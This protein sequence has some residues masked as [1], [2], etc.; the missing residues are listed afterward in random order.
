MTNNPNRF[1]LSIEGE[2]DRH[3]RKRSEALKV[4]RERQQAGTLTS[5]AVILDTVTGTTMEVPPRY[6]EPESGG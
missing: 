5:R 4:I 6:F 3:Y 2:P 1:Q